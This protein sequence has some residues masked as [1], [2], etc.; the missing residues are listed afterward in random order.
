MSN[1]YNRFIELCRLNGVKPTPLVKEVGISPGNL[2]RW[3]EGATTNT[4]ILNILS[5]R[6]NVS[7][8]YFFLDDTDEK[9]FFEINAIKSVYHSLKEHP[10]HILSLMTGIKPTLYELIRVRDYLGCNLKDLSPKEYSDEEIKLATSE[11]KKIKFLDSPK[12]FIL[13]GVLNK[14]PG[15]KEFKYFQVGISMIVL[16]NLVNAGIDKNKLL[17][18][19]LCKKKIDVLVDMMMPKDGKIPLNTSDLRN[20]LEKCEVS[21]DYMFTGKDATNNY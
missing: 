5:E 7:A 11:M 16:G 18:I 4:E 19:G 13:T 8:D 15:G 10:H 2:K 3:E 1:F 20:I 21:F 9:T 14:T 12:E 17:G 6:F